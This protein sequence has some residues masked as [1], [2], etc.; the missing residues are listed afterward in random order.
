MVEHERIYQVMFIIV[1]YNVVMQMLEWVLSSPLVQVHFILS[2]KWA[3]IVEDSG[4]FRTKLWAKLRSNQVFKALSSETLSVLKAAYISMASLLDR[5][6]PLPG[7]FVWYV[8]F[9]VCRPTAFEIITQKKRTK[10]D[11][12]NDTASIQ[13]AR[14]L[15]NYS[16]W[17]L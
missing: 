10:L 2:L 8:E 15:N 9:Y 14:Q 17:T 3:A 12:V 4:Y 5:F 7:A 13:Q 1:S 16:H 6:A 11:I